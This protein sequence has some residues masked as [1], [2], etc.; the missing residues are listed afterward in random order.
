MSNRSTPPSDVRRAHNA[1]VRDE[2]HRRNA[3]EL[4]V[5]RLMEGL[6][7]TMSN[8][9]ADWRNRRD[10]AMSVLAYAEGRPVELVWQVNE[11]IKSGPTLAELLTTPGAMAS[12]VDAIPPADREKLARVLAELPATV[13]S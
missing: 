9:D 8:G 10:A 11:T 7:A 6:D 2:L 12:L 13:E 3:V 5:D 1:G 4:A